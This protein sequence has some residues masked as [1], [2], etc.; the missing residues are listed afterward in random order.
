MNEAMA[1]SKH[2][3]GKKD[4]CRCVRRRGAPQQ[5]QSRFVV[6]LIDDLI[7]NVEILI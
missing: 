2:A 6:F 1:V 7:L 4:R 3:G 5:S